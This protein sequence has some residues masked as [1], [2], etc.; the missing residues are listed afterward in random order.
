MQ[1]THFLTQIFNSQNFKPEDLEK[2]IG[3]YKRV[4]FAKNDY[5]ISDK[6]SGNLFLNKKFKVK[7]Q[8]FEEH[9]LVICKL[10]TRLL[11]R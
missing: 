9:F 3:Q 1:E 11:K 2:V 8:F 4:E 7:F 6:K 10:T 5:L